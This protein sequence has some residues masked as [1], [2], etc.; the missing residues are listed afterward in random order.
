MADVFV[1]YSR[2]DMDFV[3]KLHDALAE[4]NWQAWVDWQDIP[5]SAEWLKEILQA[6]RPLTTFCT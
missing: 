2:K 4:H 5:P 6:S 1:S 3:R